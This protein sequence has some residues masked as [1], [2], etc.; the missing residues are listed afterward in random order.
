MNSPQ[1][2]DPNRNHVSLARRT[3]VHSVVTQANSLLLA[4]ALATVY[5][6]AVWVPTPIAH[7]QEPAAAP[8]AA[9][10]PDQPEHWCSLAEVEFNEERFRYS[11]TGD[12]GEYEVIQPQTCADYFFLLSLGAWPEPNN[13][14]RNGINDCHRYWLGLQEGGRFDPQSPAA[15]TIWRLLWVWPGKRL[16]PEGPGGEIVIGSSPAHW[17]D[18]GQ[19]D[20]APVETDS[21]DTVASDGWTFRVHES[22]AEASVELVAFVDADQD[23]IDDLVT[24]QMVAATEGSMCVLYVHIW[25]PSRGWFTLQ[26]SQNWLGE[27]EAAA[28]RTLVE[29]SAED[30]PCR[31]DL[32][33][34][35]GRE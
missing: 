32:R 8:D 20:Y 22:G 6:G 1:N 12:F 31:P 21:Q 28:V 34:L 27:L 11:A 23:G 18:F 5:G 35:Q 10:A 24:T 29:Q 17:A 30:E 4:F 3:G 26:E 2:S 14:E 19:S 13:I 25:S 33:T 7:A 15:G 16:I 9:V